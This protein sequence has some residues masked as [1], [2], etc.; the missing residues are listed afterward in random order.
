MK[1]QRREREKKNRSENE[2]TE[3]N[4]ESE[5]VHR[6]FEEENNNSNSEALENREKTLRVQKR[7][8]KNKT[9]VKTG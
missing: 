1:V 2:M 9:E 8:K 7:V 5:S 6:R 3:Y 4:V